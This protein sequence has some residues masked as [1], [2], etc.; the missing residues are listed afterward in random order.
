MVGTGLG[1]RAERHGSRQ[2][3]AS[4]VHAHPPSYRRGVRGSAARG[5]DRLNRRASAQQDNPLRWFGRLVATVLSLVVGLTSTVAL[6][7]MALAP[8]ALA[9]G[10]GVGD[11]DL[12]PEGFGESGFVVVGESGYI[13]DQTPPEI[14]GV[15]WHDGRAHDEATGLP[16]GY[17]GQANPLARSHVQWGPGNSPF[18]AAPAYLISDAVRV[19]CRRLQP[20]H[21]IDAASLVVG[22]GK[23]SG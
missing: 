15:V 8:M 19:R 23:T 20:C 9:Y 12:F 22:C 18:S 1:S 17:H 6:A 13:G 10:G 14:P 11:P 4:E 16:L 2:R 5:F 3:A 7:P 21:R